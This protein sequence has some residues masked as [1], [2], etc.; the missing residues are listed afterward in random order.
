[1][2][3]V[4]IAQPVGQLA[5][6]LFQLAHFVAFSA[7]SGIPVAGPALRRSARHFPVLAVDGACRYP[8]PAD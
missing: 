4:V 2:G 6:R 3:T 8:A 5:N 1:M 7:D